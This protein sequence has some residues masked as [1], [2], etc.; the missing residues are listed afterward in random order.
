MWCYTQSGDAS[1]CFVLCCD[2]C[3]SLYTSV[4]LSVL[5]FILLFLFSYC[6]ELYVFVWL[7]V[8][9]QVCAKTQFS[10]IFFSMLF[11]ESSTQGRSQEF[12][13]EGQKS[14]FRH[15]RSRY[16]HR[17]P[18]WVWGK[19]P[20]TRKICWQ[21]DWMPQIPNCSDKKISA[22][23]FRRGTC[24]PCPPSLHPWS[25]SKKTKLYYDTLR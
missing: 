25:T 3:R 14:G 4:S 17:A 15:Q 23:Q 7:H 22:W 16:R 12:V 2:L 11:R 13:S 20:K 19:A 8:R 5:F 18:G 24:T 6:T 9:T 21:F 1:I 10:L